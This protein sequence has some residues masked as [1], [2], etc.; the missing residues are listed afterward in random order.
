MKERD[1]WMKERD[2]RVIGGK[3]SGMEERDQLMKERE[4]GVIGEKGTK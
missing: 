2:K 1:Q 3:K 4:K